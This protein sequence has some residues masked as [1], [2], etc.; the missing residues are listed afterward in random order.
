MLFPASQL[1]S[2]Y[3]QSLKWLGQMQTCL[4]KVWRSQGLSKCHD[5][6]PSGHPGW[7]PEILDVDG[8]NFRSLQRSSNLRFKPLLVIHTWKPTSQT[9]KNK[10]LRSDETNTEVLYV[11][12]LSRIAKSNS[13]SVFCSR[14]KLALQRGKWLLPILW[15]ISSLSWW[16]SYHRTILWAPLL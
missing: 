15:M 6:E 7:A 16:Y 13:P 11:G 3:T 5:Q 4:Y 12:Y 2:T 10:I 1:V 9:V 8:R 14:W